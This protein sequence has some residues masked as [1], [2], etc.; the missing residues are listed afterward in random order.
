MSDGIDKTE[1]FVRG[2][3]QDPRWMIVNPDGK[4][5]ASTV[6]VHEEERATLIGNA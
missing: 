4:W 1:P 6:G 5:I 2:S 3:D